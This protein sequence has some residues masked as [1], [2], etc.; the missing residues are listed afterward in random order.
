LQNNGRKFR[1]QVGEDAQEQRAQE[2]FQGPFQINLGRL[3]HIKDLYNNAE[4]GSVFEPH[5]LEL[6]KSTL[7]RQQLAG[8]M[9]PDVLLYSCDHH[10]L[11]ARELTAEINGV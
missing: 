4:T 10:M 2:H 11:T 5:Y 1:N 6:N 9:H 7:W 3:I 8:S